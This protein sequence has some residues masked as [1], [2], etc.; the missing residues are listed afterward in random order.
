METKKEDFTEIKW[1]KYSVSKE[2]G[3]IV[4]EETANIHNEILPI[5][6]VYGML[7]SF[8]DGGKIS[9][10]LNH[11]RDYR[12]LNMRAAKRRYAKR[13]SIN[14]NDINNIIKSHDIL[15][16]SGH[17]KLTNFIYDLFHRPHNLLVGTA[18]MTIQFMKDVNMYKTFSDTLKE[19]LDANLKSFET[20]DLYKTINWNEVRCLT[21]GV[22]VKIRQVNTKYRTVEIE[23]ILHIDDTHCMIN[24]DKYKYE[25]LLIIIK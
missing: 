13:H 12:H 23:T 10:T 3:N 1:L 7:N 14:V 22:S 17:G 11:H 16:R 20:F 5:F 8:I 15:T 4:E 19:T 2:H 21:E 18:I 9:I 25:D 24:D 6:E